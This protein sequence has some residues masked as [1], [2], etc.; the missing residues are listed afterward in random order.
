MRRA[1]RIDD[2]QIAI[3]KALRKAGCS[4]LSLAAVGNGCPDLLVFR[5][6]SASLSVYNFDARA[7]L[8]RKTVAQTFGGLYMLE[9]KDGDKEPARIRLRPKQTEFKKH[10]PVQVVTDE[11]EALKAVGL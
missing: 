3:V 6:V 8:S 4:V 5:G 11:E 7:P 1:A 10:W 9:V 2:N